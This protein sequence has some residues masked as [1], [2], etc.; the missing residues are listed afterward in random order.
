MLNVKQNNAYF[1]LSEW[2]WCGWIRAAIIPSCVCKMSISTNVSYLRLPRPR[3]RKLNSF[4][5]VRILSH[6]IDQD[7]QYMFQHYFLVLIWSKYRLIGCILNSQ[8]NW[9]YKYIPSKMPTLFMDTVFTCRAAYLWTDQSGRWT[10]DSWR[11]RTSSS[12][13]LP[14]GTP[15]ARHPAP[16]AGN[17]SGINLQ[18]KFLQ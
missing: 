13:S 3:T 12:S 14:G 2:G 11:W 16:C 4:W 9:L 1:L 15:S 6:S 10:W 8:C 5:R 17:M 7:S 18:I